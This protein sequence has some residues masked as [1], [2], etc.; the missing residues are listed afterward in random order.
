MNVS[1]GPGDDEDGAGDGVVSIEALLGREGVENLDFQF[2]EHDLGRQVWMFTPEQRHEQNAQCA[3][4]VDGG[5]GTLADANARLRT[6]CGSDRFHPTVVMEA[7]VA[8]KA[9]LIWLREQS[10]DWI[11]VNRGWRPAP[12]EGAPDRGGL[13]IVA[14]SANGHGFGDSVSYPLFAG[15]MEAEHR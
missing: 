2:G 11:S 3:D 8:T 14:S 10:Y 6:E 4:E 15:R 13:E 7:G 9:N 5:A 1:A 12:A